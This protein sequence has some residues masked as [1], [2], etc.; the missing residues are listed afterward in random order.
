MHGAPLVGWARWA[1]LSHFGRLDR[2]NPL[3]GEHNEETN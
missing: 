2:F 1:S 3:L